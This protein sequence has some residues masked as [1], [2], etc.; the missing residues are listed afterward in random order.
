MFDETYRAT[1]DPEHRLLERGTLLCVVSSRTPRAEDRA[2]HTVGAQQTLAV[3][4]APPPLPG[5]SSERPLSSSSGQ[6]SIS[7]R[8]PRCCAPQAGWAYVCLSFGSAQTSLSQGWFSLTCRRLY[9]LN[10][11]GILFSQCFVRHSCIYWWD[12]FP[13]VWISHLT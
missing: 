10:T 12:Y 4:S 11:P 8:C 2:L 6:S 3:E 5:R 13:D 7:S 1:C 9:A